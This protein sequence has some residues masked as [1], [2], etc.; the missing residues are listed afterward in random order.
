MMTADPF[1]DV[2]RRTRLGSGLRMALG[3]EPYRCVGLDRRTPRGITIR[4]TRH[5][6]YTPAAPEISASDRY[7]S[8][9]SLRRGSSSEY[10]QCQSGGAVL[11]ARSWTAVVLRVLEMRL[12]LRGSLGFCIT[13]NLCARPR[14]S[15]TT[16]ELFENP[17]LP[18]VARTLADRR[19]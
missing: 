11:V 8:G 14:S 15:C 6:S 5:W 13:S 18:G 7:R 12:I 2:L 1:V 4:L 17:T 3:T 10:P 9:F 16:L 19:I